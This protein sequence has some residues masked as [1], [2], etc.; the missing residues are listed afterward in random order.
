MSMS[1]KRPNIYKTARRGTGYTQETAAELLSVSVE[2]VRAYEN[3]YRVPPDDIVE[4]MALC[5]DTPWLVYQH[6]Q[7]TDSLVLQIVPK[8]QERSVLEMAVRIYNRLSRFS[9]SD[10]LEH[11]MAIAEDGVIDEQERPQFDEIV[12]EL[13]GIIQSGLELQIFSDKAEQQKSLA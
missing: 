9:E 7:E 8:L 11:L 1:G 6:L 3:G 5:Y 4:H 2:S 13:K 12:A 10:S